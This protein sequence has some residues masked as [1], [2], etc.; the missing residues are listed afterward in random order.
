MAYAHKKHFN[1]TLLALLL[2]SQSTLAFSAMDYE[3]SKI[4]DIGQSAAISADGRVIAGTYEISNDNYRPFIIIDGNAV[5]LS[6]YAA[7]NNSIYVSGLSADGNIATG[8]IVDGNNKSDSKMYI[9][10]TNTDT[11]NIPDQQAFVS[12]ASLGISG[13]GKT[14]IGIADEKAFRFSGQDGITLLDPSETATS[15]ANGVNYDGSVIVG[16]YISGSGQAFKYTGDKGMVSLGTLREGNA[17]QSGANAVSADGLVTVGWSNISEYET[18]AMSHT[19]KDGMRDLGTLKKDNSGYSSASS[20]SHDGQFIVGS[21]DN[22]DDIARGFVYVSG[23]K[24]MYELKPIQGSFEGESSAEA[25]SADGKVVAG[26]VQ[27]D[28]NETSAVLWKLDYKPPMTPLEPS[29]PVDPSEP[30]T[31]LEPS[32]PVDPAEPVKPVKPIL[33]LTPVDPAD[34]GGITVSDPVDI[35]ETRNTVTKLAN[36]SY[37]VLD[38]YQ[39][40]LYNLAESRCQMGEDNYC[41][42]LFTQYDNVHQNN[43]VATGVFGSFRLPAENWTLGASLNFAVNTHL[44]DGYDTRG[45]NNPGVGAW[46]RYQENKDNSGFNSE[47]SAAFLQ[48]GLEITRQAQRGTETGKGNSDIKGYSVKFTTGYGITVSE[49]TLVTPLTAIK[50]HNVTRAGYTESNGIDFPATYGRAGNKN[51]DLQ[52]GVDLKHQ[53]NKSTELDAGIGADIKLS[54]KRDAF[55]G[56]IQYVNDDAYIYDR[57]NSQSIKPYARAGVNYFI[58]ENS[59]IRGDIGYHTTDYRNDGLQVGLSYS[60]HW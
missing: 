25:I 46:L 57:G 1:K 54:H 7:G 52:L 35:I 59:T 49:N 58:T 4:K 43:R 26:Y 8:Y 19:D 27:N 9:Y 55:T 3:V 47:L 17:G 29:K 23:E 30:L 37:Q 33:P 60:Y 32:E 13:D 45:S 48:Q 51:L 18:H 31:P 11:V 24:K 42:G 22:E 38:L 6:K 40:A 5:D 53:F 50:Y 44:A 56:H 15:T 20:V 36:S 28:N 16:R 21:S 39:T 34:N 41:T 2:T 12:V 10:D 14:V